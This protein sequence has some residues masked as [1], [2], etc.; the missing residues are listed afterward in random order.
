M[1]P[2]FFFYKN[3]EEVDDVK[4]AN[5]KELRVKLE[6]YTK[7]EEHAT[8]PKCCCCIP[9]HVAMIIIGV[10]TAYELGYN[11]WYSM[12]LSSNDGSSA[13]IGIWFILKLATIASFVWLIF[14]RKNDQ[15][16]KFTF[17]TYTATQ[18][19]EIILVVVW[20][21]VAWYSHDYYCVSAR[22][23]CTPDGLC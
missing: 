8:V 7:V 10:L 20:F 4:G 23:K 14:L 18:V 11:T 19:L 15:A 22:N 6:K 5:Y 3:G 1:L 17:I 9:L 2:S 16:R 13:G 12:H 21:L